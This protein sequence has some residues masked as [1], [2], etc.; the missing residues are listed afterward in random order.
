MELIFP[1]I[2]HKQAALDFRQ[3]HF[4]HG[5]M[6]M[7]GDGGLDTAATYESWLESIQ[8][9]ATRKA[10]EEF[11]PAT[12]YF[13]VKDGRMVGILQIRHTLN[14]Y[15]LNTYGHIGYGVRPTERRKGYATEMLAI[16]L[17]KCRELGIEKVLISCDRD[18]IASAK[19]ILKNGGV[20]EKDIVDDEGD[21]VQQYWI[22][23]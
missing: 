2:G 14:Q 19:T 12:V 22:T 9:A 17:G 8:A 20:Y 1:A 15:L 5:E 13:G 10:S 23:L 16:A 21:T 6:V 3:E 18:N 4:D 7:H 11:V